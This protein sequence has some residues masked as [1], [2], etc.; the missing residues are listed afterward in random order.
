MIKKLQYLSQYGK[1]YLLKTAFN[2]YKARLVVEV[3]GVMLSIEANE[4]KT[5]SIKEAV[6]ALYSKFQESSEEITEILTLEGSQEL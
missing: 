3:P 2:S 6:D 1:V 5:A 4:R